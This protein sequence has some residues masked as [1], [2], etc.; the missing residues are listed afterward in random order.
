MDAVSSAGLEFFLEVQRWSLY[1][2]S[3]SDLAD[4]AYG[5][6][7]IRRVGSFPVRQR[8]PRFDLVALEFSAP[9]DEAISW[10]VS[11][12]FPSK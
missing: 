4:V 9:A 1:I 12:V 11:M 3:I 2:L 10:T 8:V 6:G 7:I 5:C